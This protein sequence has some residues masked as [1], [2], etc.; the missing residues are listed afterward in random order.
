MRGKNGAACWFLCALA[1]AALSF[2]TAAC[3]NDGGGLGGGGGSAAE[4]FDLDYRAGAD[5]LLDLRVTAS[6][7][8]AGEKPALPTMSSVG[9]AQAHAIVLGNGQQVID[10]AL[11]SAD[12]LETGDR[13][14]V[15]LEFS[16]ANQGDVLDSGGTL[17]MSCNFYWSHADD[18]SFAL[19]GECDVRRS[20]G[21]YAVTVR[22]SYSETTQFSGTLTFAP[23]P[24]EP[25]AYT[26]GDGCS[27]DQIC[28]SLDP[29]DYEPGTGYCMPTTN[30]KSQAQPCSADCGQQLHIQVGSQSTCIC[31]AVCGVIE[32]GGGG[33]PPICDPAYGCI[34]F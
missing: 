13:F 16:R 19:S 14:S 21:G 2:G 25:V 3:R 28:L 20:E 4:G 33:D 1:G 11:S 27:S 23:V 34:D 31:T 24:N 12:N 8:F 30:L 22:Q 18:S 5:S 17:A 15:T 10:L 26:P 7:S 6:L 32:S 9:V 29:N